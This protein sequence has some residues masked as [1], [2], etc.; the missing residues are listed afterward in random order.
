MTSIS[1]ID[2][3]TIWERSCSQENVEAVGARCSTKYKGGKVSE[4]TCKK[5]C[6][7]KLSFDSYR[8]SNAMLNYYLATKCNNHLTMVDLTK[9]TAESA[10]D[11]TDSIKTEEA[12]PQNQP[13]PLVLPSGPA[14]SPAG[15][16][17]KPSTSGDN[18]LQVS[19][20]TSIF[21]AI[22]ILFV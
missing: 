4:N 6:T 12:N 3:S 14:D 8:M 9:M 5:T 19:F 21:L 10:P 20:C 18:F 16:T 2:G 13:N 11:D 15:V 7:G 1:Q 17:I 22:T